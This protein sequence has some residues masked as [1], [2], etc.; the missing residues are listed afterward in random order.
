MTKTDAPACV[1]GRTEDELLDTFLLSLD[2][3]GS[4]RRSYRIAMRQFF[5]FVRD[6][7]RSLSSLSR[8]DILS[9]KE[10]LLP[11]NGRRHSELTVSLYLSAVRAFYAWAEA[12]ML[13]PN[14]ARD[15]KSPRRKGRGFKKMHLSESEGAEYLDRFLHADREREK[16]V[17]DNN[18]D[19]GRTR[20]MRHF[21]NLKSM[22]MRDYAMMSLMLYCGLRTIEV[23][24]LDVGDVTYR[25]GRRVLMVRGK[26][27]D[28]KDAYV[29]LID[30]AWEPVSR[31]LSTRK[32]ALP[33][34]PLFVCE[35]YGIRGRRMSTR[36]VQ[37]ICKA[38]MRAIGL[39][40]HEYSAHSLRHTTGV[41]IVR[42]G[43]QLLDVQTVLRHA[44]TATSQ[45]Y[46]ESA[47]EE[48]RIQNAPESRLEGCFRK[49]K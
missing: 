12:Q 4:S 37:A 1:A 5:A 11:E 16:A 44:S 18:A 3:S 40:G 21:P 26:G 15:V 2:V 28:A 30:E 49:A 45:I 33:G 34:E 25:G 10:S 29:V 22:S 14:I 42:H 48:I 19:E 31:Y 20:M 13:Y 36:R 39:D 23:V 17:A 35:G 46:I 6:T 32:G 7:G 8:S 47:M 38:G 41:M 43:G 27:R 9:F 24:R